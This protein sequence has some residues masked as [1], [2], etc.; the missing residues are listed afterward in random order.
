MRKG[1]DEVHLLTGVGG[2]KVYQVNLPSVLFFFS[3]L[4]DT[5]ERT[6]ARV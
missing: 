1:K 6:G 4:S 3:S 5:L 2:Y